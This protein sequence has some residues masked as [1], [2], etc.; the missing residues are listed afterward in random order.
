MFWFIIIVLIIILL[1]LFLKKYK[2]GMTQSYLDGVDIV[3]WINLDREPERKKNME[4]MFQDDAFKNI[5]NERIIAIDGNNEN[6]VYDKFET[7]NYNTGPKEYACLLSHLNAIKKFNDSN[8]HTALILE[9]DCTIELKQYWKKSVREIMKNAP[10]DWEIIMLNYIILSGNEHPF[11]KWDNKIDYTDNLP[12]G[13]LS[14]IINKKGSNKLIEISNNKYVLE[15][16][17]HVADAYIY[18]I[19]K[20]YCYKYPMFIYPKDNDSYIADSHSHDTNNG[21]NIIIENYSKMIQ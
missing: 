1:F 12:S 21:R 6:T 5:P 16:I 7:T 9:D 14:Y 2:E 11:S 17:N 4:K 8:Y 18:T 13:T 19:P 15:N 20:T 10:N 3:Y